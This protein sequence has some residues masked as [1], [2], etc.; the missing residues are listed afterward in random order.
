[1]ANEYFVGNGNV[2]LRRIADNNGSPTEGWWNIGDAN[3]LSISNSQTF[4]DHYESQSG[5]RTRAARWLTE[6]SV[7]FSLSVQN[8]SLTSL[9][10]LLQGTQD[11]AVAGAAIVDESIADVYEG[12]ALYTAYPGIS[13]VSIK[14]GATPLVLDTDYTIDSAR[15]GEITILVGAPNISGAGPITLLVSYTH[16]GIEGTIRALTENVQDFEIRFDG[17]N[18][19]APN[20]PV[21]IR[22]GRAQ[23]NATE[24]FGLI[25]T[26]ITSLTFTGAILPDT[27]SEFYSVTMA[28]DVA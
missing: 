17:I 21:I 15:N 19:T 14:E 20:S 23:F 25:G 13:T 7:E 22:I 1:M 27:N 6:T 11:A 8:F 28:N 10:A 26:D 3:E 18:L 9:A 5:N 4:G 24:D 16:V 2:A 12:Q